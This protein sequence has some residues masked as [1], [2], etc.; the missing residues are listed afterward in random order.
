MNDHKDVAPSADGLDG[1]H[2]ND[3]ET[4]TT[5]QTN[6]PSTSDT[7]TEMPPGGKHRPTTPK[8]D[9]DLSA[10]LNY[11]EKAELI[12]FINRVIDTMQRHITQVFDSPGLE[13]SPRPALWEKLPAH[14]R[15]LSL[16][17]PQRR[18]DHRRHNKE[19]IRPS[20]T[21]TG[22]SGPS[23]EAYPLGPA[24]DQPGPR[25]Q[26]LKK[27]ILVVFGKWRAT[28]T[29]RIGDISV[30][31]ADSQGGQSPYGGGRRGGSYHRGRQQRG[32]RSRA[33]ARSEMEAQS[34]C[35]ADPR[36][37]SRPL[38]L[39]ADPT[40]ARMYPPITTSL[41]TMSPEKRV[42]L[43]H[44][45]LLLLVSTEGYNAY[46]RVLLL[47]VTSSLFLPLRILADDE[48]R[49]AKSLGQ[50]TKDVNFDELLQKKADEGKTSKKHKGGFGATGGGLAAPLV[51]AGIGSILGGFN[52]G[53]T[54][55]SGILGPM[56]E[57]PL[58]IGALLGQPGARALGKP[59]EQYSKDIMNF[60]FIPFHG[61]TGEDLE[62]G[63]IVPESR[64]LRAVI[65]ISGWLTNEADVTNPWKALGQ[66]TEAYGVRWDTE[67]LLKMGGALETVLKSAA[68][69]MAKKEIIARTSELLLP[70][71]PATAN[72]HG[73][74]FTCLS[75]AWWPVGLMK[76]SKVI[77]NPWS[78]AMVRA[79]KLGSVLA[80]MI[81]NKTPGERGVTLIGYS[82]GARA[83][84]SCLN[85][86]A[87]RR[88][89]GLVENVVMM[90]TPAPSDSM[91]WCGMRSVISG[92]FVNVFSRN[93]Y[94]LGFLY[95]TAS[96]AYGVAG[97][98]R[99]DGIDGIE[100]VD[101]SAKISGHLR[102]QYLAGSILNHIG[103][104]D[105]DK[106]KVAADEAVLVS[107]EEKNR[108]RER[109]RDA[110]EF[111]IEVKEE[112]P[113]QPAI[114]TRARRMKSKK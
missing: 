90:G 7:T 88:A 12:A 86:L 51:S 69:S 5:K 100:N 57:N 110:V 87:E 55:A 22:S 29:K 30:R 79:D 58:L 70:T 31:R 61:S 21:S 25:L 23:L 66:R 28:V 72:Q 14:L 91:T 40:L 15:D 2:S 63:K 96:I 43:L 32:K 1:N 53:P 78:V 26:E 75:Q 65:C 48:A 44:C 38:V 97:L 68:W 92:R 10:L 107:A 76:V 113:E 85:I 46:S 50:I 64:R 36:A 60:A 3:A 19:N 93:D 45:L 105:I 99:I 13:N 24:L 37:D 95:R 111:N 112:K 4:S 102:Y 20:T 54:V 81:M 101:V 34:P 89:V 56:S 109:K 73:P 94:I 62:I 82:L 39:E 83:I 67:S 104:E 114:R 98:Q 6:Q 59:M 11:G 8:R 106:Q 52:L 77:D 74:V 42:L 47:H 103:W 17:P 80:D 18:P 33:A 41:A 27:E 84:Y 9:V 16:A 49:V 108:E 35:I 71:A